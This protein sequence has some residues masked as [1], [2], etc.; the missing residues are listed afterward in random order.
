MLVGTKMILDQ[1]DILPKTH[2]SSA[3]NEHFY[4]K[5]FISPSVYNKDKFQ[6]QI[7]TELILH[8]LHQD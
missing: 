2:I 4:F 7:F 1:S 5:I 6:Q 8:G 3:F